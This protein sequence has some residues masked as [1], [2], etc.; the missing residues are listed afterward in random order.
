MQPFP[1]GWDPNVSDFLC[2]LTTKTPSN[3]KFSKKNFRFA[4]AHKSTFQ[5]LT[6]LSVCSQV[7]ASVLALAAATIECH[8][9]V[10][11]N[12]VR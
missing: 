10:L 4:L 5:V 1:E 6:Y 2:R 12:L 9:L 7:V 8:P 11:L 3:T